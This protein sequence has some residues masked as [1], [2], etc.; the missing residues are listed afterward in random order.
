MAP[1]LCDSGQGTYENLALGELS[2]WLLVRGQRFN[3]T[4]A[5]CD[6]AVYF[7]LNVKQRPCPQTSPPAGG[8]NSCLDAEQ[9]HHTASFFLTGSLVGPQFWMLAAAA[10]KFCLISLLFGPW[11]RIVL[12]L[13]FSQ[14][15][16]FL[17]CASQATCVPWLLLCLK[18]RSWYGT[19]VTL[20][21]SN[22]L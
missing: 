5:F 3:L 1:A 10:N 18:P 12:S 7:P 6:E 22:R 11:L 19:T 14:L 9:A 13:H 15:R 17:P 21:L 4:G 8:T 16:C 2:M 20:F